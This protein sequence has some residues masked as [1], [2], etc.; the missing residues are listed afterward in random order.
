MITEE[1]KSVSLIASWTGIAPELHKK[2][3][4][5]KLSKQL[6][7][8]TVKGPNGFLWINKN[9]NLRVTNQAFTVR[10]NGPYLV[11][12]GDEIMVSMVAG[13]YASSELSFLKNNSA[14]GIMRAGAGWDILSL[15]PEKAL[16]SFEAAAKLSHPIA[17]YNAALMRIQRDK[18]GDH[19]AA[20][21]LLLMSAG[22]GDQKSKVLLERLK[23]GL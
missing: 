6:D 15:C 19:Q 21:K 3:L 17:A 10:K 5:Q 12:D 2:S 22:L 14:E 8:I 18:E 23:K 16:R 11:A 7:G 9:G 1:I 20:K 4:A 13:W